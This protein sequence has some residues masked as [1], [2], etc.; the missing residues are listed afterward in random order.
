MLATMG[1]ITLAAGAPT[2]AIGKAEEFVA[3]VRS[4]LANLP[5]KDEPVREV[6]IRVRRNSNDWKSS[7][8]MSAT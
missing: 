4:T 8:A 3:D 5:S 6:A 7:P 1:P 2:V